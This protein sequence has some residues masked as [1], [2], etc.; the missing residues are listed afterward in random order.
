VNRSRPLPAT[1]VLTP[2]SRRP[3]ELPPHTVAAVLSARMASSQSRGPSAAPARHRASIVVPSG[4]NLVFLKFCL[5]SI[6]LNTPA[7]GYEIIVVDNGSTDG[8]PAYLAGMAEDHPQIRAIRNPANRGFAAAV[9]Q[10]LAAATGDILVLLNDDTIV[11]HGWLDG[12]CRGL[13]DETVGL[14]GPVT[15]RSG[16]EAQIEVEYDTYAG[17]LRFARK[18]RRSHRDRTR[19]LHMLTMFCLA[20]R[21]DLYERVGPLDEQFEVGMFEDDDYAVRVRAAGYRVVCADALFVHHFGATSL[22]KLAAAG[23]Y[24]T[25]FDVNRKRFEQKW[26]V[27]WMPRRR[28]AGPA[29]AALIDRIREAVAQSVPSNATVAV[30][31]RGDAALVELPHCRTR[32]FPGLDDGSYAGYNPRDSEEAIRFLEQACRQGASFLV[33]PQTA[34]WWLEHYEAFAAHLHATAR[35]IVASDACTMF[36]LAQSNQR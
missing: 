10:G 4:N 18:R 19:D 13:E 22:G 5:T 24:G 21:R 15:N 20:F 34:R 17:F 29:Y 25:L 27:T 7:Q 11:P 26:Q 32:H 28:E 16:D 2:I 36:E 1:L 33:V 30:I 35:V 12:L 23:E 9:N 31:S 14:L 3:T 8:T 6:L